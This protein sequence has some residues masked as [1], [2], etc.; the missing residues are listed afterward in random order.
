MNDDIQQVLTGTF[1]CYTDG[2]LLDEGKEIFLISIFGTPSRVK[3][4]GASILI[5]DHVYV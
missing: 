5:G 3:A 2:Y 4:V 1:G